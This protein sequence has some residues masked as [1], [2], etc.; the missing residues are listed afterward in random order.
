MRRIYIKKTAVLWLLL[1]L[2][3]SRLKPSFQAFPQSVRDKKTL[4]VGCGNSE[5]SESMCGDGFR[6][7]LSVDTSESAIKQMSARAARF[8]TAGTKCRYA[9]WFDRLV[10]PSPLV[11]SGFPFIVGTHFVCLSLC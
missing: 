7:V 8:T 1:I 9:H 2:A 10:L 6:D 11:Q 5:L 4:V 3:V